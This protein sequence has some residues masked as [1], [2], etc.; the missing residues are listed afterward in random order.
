MSDGAFVLVFSVGYLGGYAIFG[1]LQ[2]LYGKPKHRGG[3]K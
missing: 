2:L 1:W 3:Q